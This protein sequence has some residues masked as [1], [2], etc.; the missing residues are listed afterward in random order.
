MA[1]DALRL[2]S[3]LLLVMIH[4]LLLLLEQLLIRLGVRTPV[5]PQERPASI[6]DARSP[7]A[8]ALG[9]APPPPSRG[10]E[11][12]G[13]SRGGEGGGARADDHIDSDSEYIIVSP[14]SIN[15]SR[16]DADNARRWLSG[17]DG[18]EGFD[19]S[20]VSFELYDICKHEHFC[21]SVLQ[22]A[23]LFLCA[24]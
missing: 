3:L 16:R 9:N 11:G 19:K 18:F 4:H 23:E 24:G 20:G 13:A 2:L 21:A 7:A 10:G 17:Q 5:P 12:G 1:G 8:D 14:D 22:V 15:A 6:A